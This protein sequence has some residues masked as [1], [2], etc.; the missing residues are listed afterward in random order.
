MSH[1]IEAD[2]VASELVNHLLRTPAD[3]FNNPPS[4]NFL[5]GY[6][7]REGRHEWP[8]ADGVIE[9][10]DNSGVAL[11]E[12]SIALEFKRPNEGLHG[13]LTAIGQV[14][15]YLK[16]GYSGAV[17]IIPDS[18]PSYQNTG[19]YVR[20]VLDLTSRSLSI[21]VVTYSKPDMSKLFPFAG[22]LTVHRQFSIDNVNLALPPQAYS[23]PKTQWAH[24]REG[25]T[26]PDA[27]FKY[28]QALKLLG[29]NIVSFTPTIPPRLVNA[30]NRVN[31]NQTHEKYLANCP[32]DTLPDKAWR[33]FWFKYVLH[34]TAI[35]GWTCNDQGKYVVNET[36]SKLMKPDGT[37]E[38]IWFY[39]RSDSIKT[40]TVAAL[41]AGTL[42]IADAE[43]NLVINYHDRAHSYREDVD[44]G[45]EH[46]GFVDR[47]GLLT[48]MGYKYVDA[49]ER[50]GNSNDGLP[51]MIFLNALLS[52]GSLGAFLHYIHRLSEEKFSNDPLA[53]TSFP[54]GRKPIFDN[55]A[56]LKWL[57][58]EMENSLH[59]IR[60]V[61]LRVGDTKRQ[62]FQAELAV[63]RSFG[64]LSNFRM[65]LGLVI[66]WPELQ[67]SMIFSNSSHSYN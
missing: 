30:V 29:G 53:F 59:V 64:I 45:C 26:E 31:P 56:Y 14:H 57:E 58:N 24:I 37:G 11:K 36:P 39:G 60:K 25:S 50:F 27:F 61:S 4:G 35:L 22:K 47:N 1:D 7:G 54:S 23:K 32:T 21:G 18:Y 3:C 33:Y 15:A 41:N 63:L 38:K 44:S 67:E 5:S 66:N 43:E 9:L 13:V 40:K 55:K 19:G 20:D 46:L 65:G 34:D 52:E 6:A 8:H 10:V 16:K 12:Y 48:N 42:N 51:R 62:P 2:F 28:L 49:C 17:M